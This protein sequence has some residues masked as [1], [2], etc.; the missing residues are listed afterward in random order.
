MIIRL[1]LILIVLML[2]VY[3]ILLGYVSSTL[4]AETDQKTDAILVL[5]AA[6]YYKNRKINPCLI[7]RVKHGAELYKKGLAPKVIVSGGVDRGEQ[8]SEAEV[9]AEL[10]THF[11]VPD[12]NIIL[13]DQSTSTFENILFSK[14]IIE[15]KGIHTLTI[16]TDPYHLRRAALVAKKMHLQYGLSSAIESP[17]WQKWKY[18]DRYYLLE[19]L[20]IILYF[21][22]G[23]I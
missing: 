10:A 6:A 20:H 16:V 2:L 21:L 8:R 23:K 1:I 12:E 17:C 18:L 22:E 11:G 4:Y 7:Q 19:P 5:G 14:K 3:V 13:E 15:E 9:M